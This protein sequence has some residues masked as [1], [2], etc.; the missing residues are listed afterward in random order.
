MKYSQLGIHS[1]LSSVSGK[2]DKQNA[3]F[4]G[5]TINEQ[6]AECGIVVRVTSN[7]QSKFKLLYFEQD[8]NG[9]YGLALQVPYLLSYCV[10]N[11]FSI[12]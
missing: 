2:V 11:P 9:G 5:V 12:L 10:S 6:Q 7:A 8:V 1:I 4:F 3:H